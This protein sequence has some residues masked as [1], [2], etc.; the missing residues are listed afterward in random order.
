[1]LIKKTD[2]INLSGAPG[3]RCRLFLYVLIVFFSCNKNNVDKTDP[4]PLDNL[5]S[6]VAVQWADMTLYTI[7]FSAFNSP[8]YTSRSLGYLGLA[9]YESVVNGDPSH[10]SMNGQLNGLTL[11]LPEK[12]TGYQWELVLNA[13]EDT[14]LKLLYPAPGN[15]HRFIHDKIDVLYRQLYT[16]HSKYISLTV[17]NHS[18]K[19]GQAIALAIYQWSVTDGGD[20]GY[21]RNFEPGYAFPSGPSYWVPPVRGQ[22]VSSFPLHPRWGT[23]AHL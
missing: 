13:A 16:E 12:N 3:K 7:R 18:I 14:L 2:T 21:A 11:P 10:L 19:F 8:T 23:T 6:A 17:A 22:V 4:V 20:Q 5:P 1:M 9:M 15:S